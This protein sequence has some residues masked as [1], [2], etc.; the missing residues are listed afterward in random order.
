MRR[1][2]PPAEQVRDALGRVLSSE[3]FARSE[4]ARAL[5]TYIVDQDLAGHADR[6]KGFSIAVDVFG[7]AETFDPATDTV[8]RVQAGRLRDLLDQHYAGAGARDPLRISIPRGSYVPD[9]HACE[10]DEARRVEPD[11]PVAPEAALEPQH[12]T[13]RPAGTLPS[14]LMRR[15]RNVALAAVA[16]SLVLLGAFGFRFANPPGSATAQAE[17]GIAKDEQTGTVSFDLVPSVY[18]NA[19]AAADVVNRV[20]ETLRRGLSGFDSITFIGRPPGPEKTHRRTDFVFEVKP[21]DDAGEVHLELANVASGK[22]LLSRTIHALPEDQSAT[23]NQVADLLSSVVPVSGAIYTSLANDGSS[24]LL[25]RCLDLNERYYR[26]QKPSAHRAAYRCLEDAIASGVTSPLVFSE[27]ASL[28]MQAVLGNFTYPPDPSV[29]QALAHARNAVQLAPNSANA[30]RSMGYVLSRTA[31]PDESLRWMRKAYELNTFDLGM[32]AS[33]GY[34]LIFAGRYEEGTPILQRAVSSASA[35][36]TWWDYGLFLGHF[37]LGDMQAAADALSPLG[38][39]KRAHYIAARLVVAKAHR[40]E[41]EAKAL[42]SALR[43]GNSAF[44]ANPEGFFRKGNYP[45]D[46]SVRLVQSLREAGLIGAS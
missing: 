27:L 8:V 19:S 45:Q 34:A 31:S 15:G 16:L 2:L 21:G 33:Y 26:D 9:Y 32:A 5:L 41:T 30:H 12:D 44:A 46:M 35:H 11:R 14:Y 39:S 1:T 23:T 28:E 4:R 6:L 13:V 20:S 24:S 22:V 10:G 36:P 42:L 25:V 18:L 38:A 37:M 43:E 17:A 29:E 40:D 3:T 7:K